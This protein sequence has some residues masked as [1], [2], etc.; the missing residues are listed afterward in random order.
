MS[1]ENQAHALKV[2]EREPMQPKAI[3]AQQAL[4]DHYAA[5]AQARIKAIL[6]HEN[7]KGREALAEKI[8]FDTGMSVEDAAEVLAAS[9]KATSQPLSIAGRPETALEF[10]AG[11]YT[12]SAK[13]AAQEAAKSGW[14]DA[15]KQTLPKS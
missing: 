6:T 11:G 2:N 14:G 12:P 10:G 8:A 9:P 3:P 1:R 13:A 5:E 4:K 15:F 7:A